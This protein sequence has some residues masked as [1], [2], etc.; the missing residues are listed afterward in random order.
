MLNFAALSVNVQVRKIA[1]ERED[2]LEA[3]QRRVYAKTLRLKSAQETLRNHRE[4]L[5]RKTECVVP[6]TRALQI[7]FKASADA[8]RRLQVMDLYSSAESQ[9][10][11]AGGSGTVSL[12]Y[13]SLL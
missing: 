6:S 2:A 3:M 8:Q 10:F 7:G 4:E 11:I 9:V 13:S 1:L 5:A 12:E